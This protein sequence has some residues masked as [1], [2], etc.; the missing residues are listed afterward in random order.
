MILRHSC[1]LGRRQSNRYLANMPHT[2]RRGECE[3]PILSRLKDRLTGRDRHFEV[4]YAEDQPNIAFGGVCEVVDIQGDAFQRQCPRQVWR[5]S[6]RAD[7][8][9]LGD[10]EQ[11]KALGGHLVGVVVVQRNLQRFEG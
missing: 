7:E 2:L 3:R 10:G 11:Q 4:V 1:V 5:V 8:F 9:T 6:S